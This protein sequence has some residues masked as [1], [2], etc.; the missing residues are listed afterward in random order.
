MKPPVDQR[1]T[2]IPSDSRSSA[3]VPAVLLD[4]VSVSF[5]NRKVFNSLTCSFPEKRIS[6]IL[7]ESGSGKSTIL[8]LIGGLVQ[9]T[10]GRVL[11]EGEA[12]LSYSDR[13]LIALRH[14]LGMMFQGGALLDSYSVFDNVALPLRE[15]R[16][17]SPHEIEETV[18]ST[19]KS[20]GLQDTDSLYPGDLSGGMLRRVALARAIIGK[21]AILLCDEPFSGLDP[22]AIRRIE[23]LLRVI[24]Q[25]VGM[26]M[27]IVS[28]DIPST[29]RMADHILLLIGGRAME[30]TPS[31]LRQSKDPAIAEFLSDGEENVEPWGQRS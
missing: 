9:P 2:R 24:N 21:P 30:G 4:Q 8:R 15:R 19:L 29:L 31:Q 10:S 25:Q 5:R 17:L 16:T 3:S 12:V 14:K 11:I 28:H 27:I 1:A 18:T 26:T 20:L 6:V 13:R 22:L 23:V 7:G